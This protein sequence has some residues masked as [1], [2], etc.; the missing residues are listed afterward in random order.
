MLK[1]ISIIVLISVLIFPTISIPIL[2]NVLNPIKGPL[3]VV[4]KSIVYEE[5]FSLPGLRDT[6]RV[7]YTP[8][9]IPYIEA[10]NPSDLYYVFGFIQ[11]RDRLFQMDLVRR[12]ASG[13]L[14]ELFGPDFIDTDKF[15][16][17]IG[18][19][20]SARDTY[21]LISKDPM[22]SE[23]HEYLISY[24]R[25]VNYYIEYAKRTGALPPEYYILGVDPEPWSP[26]DSIAVG[27]IISWGLAGGFSDLELLSF[28]EANG[29]DALI[30]LDFLNRSLNKP[31]LSMYKLNSYQSTPVEHYYNN[32]NA[33]QLRSYISHLNTLNTGLKKIIGVGLSNNWVISGE[34]T[35]TGYPI[36]A[37]DP[38]LSLQ[39]P[40]VWYEAGL[41]IPG[42]LS[43]FGVTFPGI[44]F[45]IIGRNE[46]VAWGFTNVGADVTDFYFYKWSG[47]K[48]LYK[49]RW[50]KPRQVNEEIYVRSGAGYR[51]IEF[52]VNITIHGPL[53]EYNGVKYAV[54][55][56]GHSPTLELVSFY[57]YNYAEDISDIIEGAKFFSVPAQNL[58]AADD[59]GNILYYPAGAYPIRN[60]TPII[61]VEGLDIINM[62]FL[63]FNGSAGEGEWSG[64]IPFDEIPHA[65]NPPQ[66]Y[67]A[68][69]NNRLVPGDYPYY[70]GWRWADRFRFERIDELIRSFID[71]G[72]KISLEDVMMIQGD[73]H[74]LAAETL[75]PM[76]ISNVDNDIIG[77]RER[78][79][80]D[81]LSKWDYEMSSDSVA[82]SI[83]TAWLY[84]LHKLLW[85]DEVEAAGLGIGFI[86][87]ETT[88]YILKLYESGKLDEGYYKWVNGEIPRILADSI[89]EAVNQLTESF[90][91]DIESWRWGDVLKYRIKHPMGDILPWLNYPM[92]D[93]QGGLFTVA[94]SGFDPSS[95]PYYVTGASSIRY[96]TMLEPSESSIPS[97]YIVLP[98]GNSGNPFNPHYHDQ[99]STWVSREYYK[100]YLYRDI[101]GVE[102]F[103]SV[104]ILRGEGG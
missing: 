18:L 81:I 7:R 69:A 54:R 33:T 27:R 15:F 78:V 26:I 40:P 82:P 16:R 47:D 32:Y 64:Y 24:T 58:V 83:Y 6:V 37:N 14:S 67:I 98:G 79:A 94:V 4:P 63:P 65:I 70:L 3:G 38:H 52:K 51:V 93:G 68:T 95:P 22:Y 102:E 13:N 74:S 103:E 46:H 80:I 57:Y 41:I 84:N 90:G 61:E 88:E 44:P 62:G 101:T 20:R 87:L 56:T 85:G 35:D 91:E 100:I 99:L 66:G 45:I 34:L 10:T 72:E 21:E 19:Y 92:Y 55:W 77:D 8:L 71:A 50:L 39:A 43:I 76:M 96:I 29:Y 42:E 1:L 59:K 12:Y 5:E 97:L 25:G 48:Y 49:G 60:N 89:K 9:G 73:I 28:L 104:I 17:V 36:L 53:Y 11:A 31:I 23:L 75:L 86:P 2:K 30:R